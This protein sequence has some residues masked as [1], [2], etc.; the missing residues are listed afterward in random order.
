MAHRARGAQE[1]A[2]EQGLKQKLEHLLGFPVRRRCRD[3]TAAVELSS[4]ST[5]GASGGRGNDL[6]N[7]R[8]ND[9]GRENV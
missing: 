3:A 8:R 9:Y 4:E 2:A 7:W 6:E 1:K 5:G